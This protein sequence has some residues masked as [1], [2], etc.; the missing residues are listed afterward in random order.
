MKSIKYGL[1]YYSF[2]KCFLSSF[3][4]RFLF[5]KSKGF[6]Q[7]SMPFLKW[8]LHPFPFSSYTLLLSPSL[9][10]FSHEHCRRANG[11]I[12]KYLRILLTSVYILIYS[13][14]IRESLTETTS[15]ARQNNNWAW[16][17]S[18]LEV[19]R[20]REHWPEVLLPIS[21]HQPEFQMDH[22]EGWYPSLYVPPTFQK[23][24]GWNPSWLID[25]L[26]TRKDPKSD[27]IWA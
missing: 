14:F 26:A 17:N 13:P 11:I 19:L 15:M 16:V 7:D 10:S 4:V 12:Y 2:L 24:S 6:G 22:K 27:Q 25:V 8:S 9:P 21:R 1:S 20:D 23:P 3:I 18:Q 5:L